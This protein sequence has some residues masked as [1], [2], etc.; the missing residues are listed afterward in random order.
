MDHE[1]TR[2]QLELAAVE[3][4]GLERLMAG[5]TATAQAVAAHLAGCPACSDELVRL[6]RAATIIRDAV[7]EQPPA[8]LKARTLAAIRTEG[9]R[10]PLVAVGAA[11]SLAAATVAI[12]DAS[13]RSAIPAPATPPASRRWTPPAR[14]LGYATTI[15]AAVLLSVVTTTAVVNNR[16]DSEMAAQNAQM[17]ALESVTA[18]TMGVSGEP[19][20]EHVD[21]RSVD[22]SATTG[23]LVYSPSTLEL[24]VVAKGLTPPPAGQEYRCWVQVNGQRERIGKM[25]FSA[26]LAYWTGPVQELQGVSDGATFGVSLVDASGNSVDTAPVLLGQL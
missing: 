17:V 14:W 24:V 3:P 1:G 4:G 15:A 26:H 21:L 25:F 2:E 7:R 8:D 18:A 19:D 11:P 12:P 10:R 5:D 22:N 23:D 16:V 6:Q 20:A 13:A 9:V